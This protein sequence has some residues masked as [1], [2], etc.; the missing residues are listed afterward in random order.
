MTL[1]EKAAWY[2]NKIR[3]RH[4]RYGFCAELHLKTPGDVTTQE[5][6]DTDNDGTWSNYYMASQAFHYGATGDETAR[7]NAWETFDALERLESINPLKGFPARTF[8]RVGFKVSD[9]DRWH[10]VGDGIWDWKAHTSSDEIIAHG[11][12]SS[13]LYQVA[14][15]TPE[16]KK[17]IATFIGKILDHIIRNDWYL[18][19]VDGKPTLWGR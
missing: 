19:D 13:V 18:I 1:A 8:E 15:R 3:Q 10:E 4:I 12:G 17:R 6:I 16:E 14:A 5:M 2:E 7:R 11:F 9:R